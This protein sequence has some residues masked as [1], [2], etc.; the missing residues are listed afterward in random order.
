MMLF[1]IVFCFSSRR[2]HTRCALVTGVQTCALPILQ[3]RKERKRR[4]NHL[5]DA[6]RGLTPIGNPMTQTVNSLATKSQERL[7]S[8]STDGQPSSSTT[9]A[10]SPGTGVAKQTGPGPGTIAFAKSLS[11]WPNASPSE[12]DT[13]VMDSL[14][15]SAKSSLEAVYENR[16]T[17]EYD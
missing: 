7:T 3:R 13:L 4:M 17:A 9:G 2:R 8:K 6:G 10:P 16:T 14:S 5:G 15:Q 11:S 1:L 12:V